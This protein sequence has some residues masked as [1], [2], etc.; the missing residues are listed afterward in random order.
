MNP[1]AMFCITLEVENVTYKSLL[2]LKE[3]PVEVNYY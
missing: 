3:V 1:K 2:E